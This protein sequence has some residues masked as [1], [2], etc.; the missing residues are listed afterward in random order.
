M[1]A[2]DQ[3]LDALVRGR[4]R[5]LGI[6]AVTGSRAIVP[7]SGFNTEPGQ[8]QVVQLE[9]GRTLEADYVVSSGSDSMRV[10]R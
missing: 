3:Q 9:D 4:F 6:I 5:E 7:P 1:P 2:F 8:V 10:S